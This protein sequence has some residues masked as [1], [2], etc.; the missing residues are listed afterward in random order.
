M[1]FSSWPLYLF[2]LR[3]TNLKRRFCLIESDMIPLP[4]CNQNNILNESIILLFKFNLIKSVKPGVFINSD[5]FFLDNQPFIF[6]LQTSI[7]YRKSRSKQN[8]KYRRNMFHC[9]KQNGKSSQISTSFYGI[10]Q[11]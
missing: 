6:Y 8:T 11:I 4:N 7:G 3:A 9:P 1:F 10:K 5:N 2:C